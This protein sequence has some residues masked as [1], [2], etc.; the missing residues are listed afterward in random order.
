MVV[1][2]FRPVGLCVYSI[3]EPLI[4]F[5]VRTFVVG[6]RVFNSSLVAPACRLPVYLFYNFT[7]RN[8]H[9]EECVC[10]VNGR[11]THIFLFAPSIIHP[12]SLTYLLASLLRRHQ[13]SSSITMAAAL[14][15]VEIVVVDDGSPG[16]PLPPPPAPPSSPVD[17]RGGGDG[18]DK[19]DASVSPHDVDPLMS[20]LV[21][22][23]SLELPVDPVLA[24][25]GRVY[26]RPY[27]NRHIATRLASGLPLYSPVTNEPISSNVRSNP[28]VRR[29]IESLIH[30]GVIRGEPASAWLRSVSVRRVFESAEN[31][32]ACAMVSA[33]RMLLTGSCP[34]VPR[35][36]PAAYRYFRRSHALGCV[37][38]TAYLGLMYCRG[39][40]QDRRSVNRVK[41]VYYLSLASERGSKFAAHKLSMILRAGRNAI[42]VESRRLRAIADGGGFLF[43]RGERVDD[44]SMDFPPDF[45]IDARASAPAGSGDARPPPR[46]SVVVP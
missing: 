19:P 41:G 4:F 28:H 36:L 31:G 6:A 37:R 35:N 24:D 39:V 30:A 20:D 29:V 2:V 32:D 46:P 42:P 9:A 18:G 10:R 33:G 11:V 26:D 21:C 25:D 15:P 16:G 17:H 38:G 40:T 3:C 7:M 43:H 22:P 27:I 5:P 14:V 1:L 34:S 12:V 13:S 23:I 45:D 44:V 8:A